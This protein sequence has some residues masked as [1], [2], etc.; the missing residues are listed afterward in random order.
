MVKKTV[1][2]SISEWL[3]KTGFPLEMEAAQAFREAGFEVRQS[4]VQLDPQEGKAREIDILAEDPDWI[5]IIEISCVVEC[6][7]SKNPWVVFTSDAA[8]QNYNRLFAFG[9]TSSEAREA[10]LKNN[11]YSR[12]LK[13]VMQRPSNKAGYA[14]RQAF[15]DKAIDT[16][17]SAAI[18]SLKACH[19]ITKDR[20]E[21]EWPSLRFAFPIIVVD[22]PLFECQMREDGEL[23]MT[24][25]EQSDFLFSSY[26]P[27][28]VGCC[29][30]V[31]TKSELKKVAIYYKNMANSIR[32]EF[33]GIEDEV[34]GRKI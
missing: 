28:S 31:V 30:K 20:K 14:F 5:G 25:V 26:F 4:S 2:D 21:R 32:A 22:A 34:L 17:Y 1:E 15:A 19:V 33:K 16:A 9:I 10:I 7:A 24:Q 8:L 13:D 11:S 27:D 3:L 23:I 12:G 29:I 6:K 18:A